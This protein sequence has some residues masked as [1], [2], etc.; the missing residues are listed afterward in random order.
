L[1]KISRNVEKR[2]S[3]HRS[4]TK[5]FFPEN[6]LQREAQGCRLTNRRILFLKR[7]PARI[8]MKI[9]GAYRRRIALG[10]QN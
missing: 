6:L 10:K 9:S 7:I 2:W 8:L 3:E 4:R 1:I 5:Y